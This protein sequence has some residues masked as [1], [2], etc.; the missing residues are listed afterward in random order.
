MVHDMLHVISAR[1]DAR[2]FYTIALRSRERAYLL[3]TGRETGIRFFLLLL[4]KS[5]ELHLSIFL[6][7]LSLLSLLLQVE[8]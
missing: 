2:D 3:E 8:E 6:L 5:L 4:L 7:L 1:C